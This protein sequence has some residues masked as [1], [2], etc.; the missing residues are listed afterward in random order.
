MIQNNR[1]FDITNV[2]EQNVSELATILESTSWE[3][4]NA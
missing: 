4:I 3:D 1:V 2:N